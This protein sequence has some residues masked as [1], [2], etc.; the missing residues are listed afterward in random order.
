MQEECWDVGRMM[1]KD[2]KETLDLVSK[3]LKY[4]NV[5][6]PWKKERHLTNKYQMVLNQFNQYR[7]EV[8]KTT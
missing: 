3:L 2:D 1:D 7:E 4:E 8:D 6:I 5:L